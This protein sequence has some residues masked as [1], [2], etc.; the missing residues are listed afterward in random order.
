[1]IVRKWLWQNYCISRKVDEPDKALIH[2]ELLALFRVCFQYLAFIVATMGIAMLRYYSSQYLPETGSGEMVGYVPWWH[3]FMIIF[4]GLGIFFF[5][6]VPL[7]KLMVQYR[8][9]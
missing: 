2:N 6:L 8:S 3:A 4:L 1:M 5:N 9:R 7:Y